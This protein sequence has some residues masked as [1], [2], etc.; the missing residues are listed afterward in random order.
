MTEREKIE[1]RSC[2]RL[3]D[4]HARICLY[5]G[6]DP[7][8]GETDQT[9]PPLEKLITPKPD[10]TF[11]ERIK[12]SLRARG[13]FVMLI[14]IVVGIVLLI[15]IST[16]VNQ[17]QTETATDVPPVPLTEVSDL[18]AATEDEESVEVEIPELG[19]EFDGEASNMETF[20]LEEGEVQP[21]PPPKDPE[22]EQAPQQ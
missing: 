1:C 4:P 3:V 14:S 13:G 11:V 8:T 19:F 12:N 6:A 9:H 18:R 20:I 7:R 15:V 10:E 5:C 22:S 2:G 17:Q 21:P 16:W